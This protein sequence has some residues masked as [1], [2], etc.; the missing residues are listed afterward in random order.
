MGSSS[1]RCDDAIKTTV[2]YRYVGLLYHLGRVLLVHSKMPANMTKF[3]LTNSF[4]FYNSEICSKSVLRCQYG[5]HLIDPAS[6]RE[7][8]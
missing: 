2:L 8:T 6:V 3:M 5:S 4:S 7:E 1:E